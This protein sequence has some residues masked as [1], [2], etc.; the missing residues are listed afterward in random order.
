MLNIPS[1]V[2]QHNHC[3]I[4]S[5]I[6]G[7]S[8]SSSVDQNQNP[9]DPLLQQQHLNLKT[10]L[11]EKLLNEQD[12]V[13][14]IKVEAF[15][16]KKSASKEDLVS[17]TGTYTIE[18]KH[19]DL[20]GVVN[21]E[22]MSEN[23][24]QDQILS[25]I[26][27]MS[28]RA[29]IDEKFGISSSGTDSVINEEMTSSK[30]TVLEHKRQM[31]KIVRERN[32]TYSLTHDLAVHLNQ[33][34]VEQNIAFGAESV[35]NSLTKATTYDVIA[36]NLEINGES[37]LTDGGSVGQSLDLDT[38]VTSQV[39]STKSGVNTELLLGKRN[40]FKE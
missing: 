2:G 19:S 27:L 39:S 16:N 32:K 14:P 10:Y 6:S 4:S 25:S 3:A 15:I 11:I 35:G 20:V 17:E 30:L 29:A 12:D 22:D 37:T 5:S 8:S 23:N 18:E 34:I 26:D 1:I 28:A 40:D 21:K 13:K 33:Q 7:S 36:N 24:E 31:Q 9:V 38:T